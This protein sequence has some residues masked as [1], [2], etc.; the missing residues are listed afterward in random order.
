M[1][2]RE[3]MM[4]HFKALNTPGRLVASESL[5]EAYDYICNEFP[6]IRLHKYPTGKQFDDWEVPQQWDLISA[7]LRDEAGNIIAS[8]EESHLFVAAYSNSVDITVTLDELKE[9]T[10]TRDDVPDAFYLEHRLAYQYKSN[11]W[12]ITVPKVRMD[13]LKPG[14]Y[15]V[16]IDAKRSDGYVGVVEYFKQ[17][18][19]DKV[20]NFS[21]HIDELCNDDMSGC[22][23]GLALVDLLESIETKYS[24]QILLVP[25]LFGTLFYAAENLEVIRNMACSI[26]LETLGQGETLTLKSS[27]KPHPY[28]KQCLTAAFEACT[29][30]DEEPGFKECSFF[31]GYGNDE[32]VLAWPGL[33]VT[34]FGIQRYPFKVYHTSKDTLDRIEPELLEQ[35]YD[36]ARKFIEILEKDCSPRFTSVLPPWLSKNKLYFD[37]TNDPERFNKFNNMLFSLDGETPISELAHRFGLTFDECYDY[38]A[39]FVEKKLMEFPTHI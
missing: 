30:Q 4:K 33:D 10:L 28:L 27:H 34:C 1:N 6:N 16:K 11:D 23:V 37:A 14:N 8:S 5:N 31:E 22:I 36:I 2:I 19:S 32:R 21:G 20:I 17:G 7:E 25:E 12:R 9:H 38:L 39:C 18:S 13:A 35:G 24:Y 15:H 3:S 26:F 29:A